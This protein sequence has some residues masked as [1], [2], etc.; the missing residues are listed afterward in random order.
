VT[1]AGGLYL[2]PAFTGL[3]APHWDMYARGCLV[4][5]NRGTTQEHVIRAALESIAYQSDDL[6]LAMQ[7]D[8]GR[9]ITA[10][11]ADGGASRNRL[12]MQMQAD[13][14]GK[15]V[16]RPVVSETTALGAAYLAGLAVGLW[17]DLGEIRA[18]W[19]C[20]AAF[21]P[22]MDGERRAVLKKGWDKAVGRSLDWAER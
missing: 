1:D 17:A 7:K 5:I 19:Q 11:K 20:E 6:L 21:T 18:L 3:G 22:Q 16:R 10:L 2:V 15:E 9:V 13:I 8:T 4:G 12:L 14:S